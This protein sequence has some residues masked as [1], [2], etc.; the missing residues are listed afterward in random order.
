MA[1]WC[2][3][4]TYTYL[5]SS[6]SSWE[7]LPLYLVRTNISRA[8]ARRLRSIY[9]LLPGEASLCAARR[10]KPISLRLFESPTRRT[11]T[12]PDSWRQAIPPRWA[13]SISFPRLSNHCRRLHNPLSLSSNSRTDTVPARTPRRSLTAPPL[14]SICLPRPAYPNSPTLSSNRSRRIAHMKSRERCRRHSNSH[15]RPRRPVPTEM[16]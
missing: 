15:S 10:R 13:D 12:C 11:S 1:P 7:I 4:V 2:G 14:Y 9:L 5:P 16:F 3:H 6:A 8:S